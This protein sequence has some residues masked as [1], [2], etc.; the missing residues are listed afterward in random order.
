MEMDTWREDK[1]KEQKWARGE[2][3][4]VQETQEEYNYLLSGNKYGQCH[5]QAYSKPSDCFCS[6]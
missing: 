2:G 4:F 5:A 6:I 1:A 3:A